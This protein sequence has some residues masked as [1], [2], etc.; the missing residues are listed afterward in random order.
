MN[1]TITRSA[2]SAFAKRAA[3]KPLSVVRGVCTSSLLAR[4]EK[5]QDYRSNNT[6]SYEHHDY[7]NTLNYQHQ[8]YSCFESTLEN[9]LE[10]AQLGKEQAE[11]TY[12]E[13]AIRSAYKRSGI[14]DPMASIWH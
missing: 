1:A 13:Q 11:S 9:V 4:E 6:S 14:S 5:V 3:T 12:W 8:E 10:M 2:A 7:D